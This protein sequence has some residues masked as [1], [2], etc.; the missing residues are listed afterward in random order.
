MQE[1]LRKL[2]AMRE[3]ARQGGGE[4]RVEAQHAKGKLHA[5]PLQPPAAQH[6]VGGRELGFASD[7]ELLFIYADNGQTSESVIL[8]SEDSVVRVVTATHR[9]V[10]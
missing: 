3:A 7:I 5:P 10:S 2:E 9:H 8:V 1:I 6:E 4:K